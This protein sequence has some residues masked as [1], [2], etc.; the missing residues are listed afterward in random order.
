VV[1]IR[2]RLATRVLPIVRPGGYP[3][4]WA[5]ATD[6][7]SELLALVKQRRRLDAAE[8][9]SLLRRGWQHSE[10]IVDEHR[11]HLLTTKSAPQADGHRKLMLYLHGGGYVF[12]PTVI[13]WFTMAKL[14][15]LIGADLAVWDYPKVPESCADRTVPATQEAWEA[16]AERYGPEHIVVVGL[17]AGG[18]LAMSLMLHRRAI[19][20]AQ[21]AGAVLCS[22][23]L[24]VTL[25]HPDIAQLVDRDR[26]LC[27]DGLRIDGELYAGTYGVDHPLIS[28]RFAEFHELPPVLLVAGS[29]EILLP[30]AVELADKIEQLGGPVRL[31]VEAGGLHAGVLLPTPEGARARHQIVAFMGRVLGP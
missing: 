1:S 19:G 3:D 21:P 25:S 24:D 9:P 5:S 2:S 22:P 10:L 28:P 31:E 13:E 18:G 27:I 11:L 12:G 15:R 4:G 26:V 17:S 16:L 14:A 23:W 6:D 7:R 8:P 30:D 20:L 29:E